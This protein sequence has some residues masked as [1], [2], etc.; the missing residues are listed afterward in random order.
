[1][2]PGGEHA[3]HGA[4]AAYVLG[5]KRW[6]GRPARIPYYNAT[7]YK[8][9][10]RKAVAAWN[11]SGA[12]LRFVA[13]PRRRAR[14]VVSHLGRVPQPQV[15]FGRAQL[16]Y[17]PGRVASVWL[18]RGCASRVVTHVAT[19][20]FGHILGLN[21]ENRRCATMN[22]VGGSGSRCPQVGAQ[23]WMRR[24]RLLEADDVRGAIRRYG[25]RMQPLAPA[26]CEVSPAP[27]APSEL[28]VTFDPA[29]RIV[30]V[31]WRNPTTPGLAF[32][33]VAAK[34]GGCPPSFDDAL[35]LDVQRGALSTASVSVGD[36]SGPYCVGVR[37]ADGY[38]RTN[39]VTTTIEV[40]PP[41]G[42]VPPPP[43]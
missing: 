40:P 28:V 8:A 24:C 23:P 35:G 21:H 39:V 42:E 33:H 36:E 18:P 15:C 17:S 26:F 29:E 6:P 41:P 30:R 11:A 2:V 10:V 16:G 14:V 20:E 13:V 1:M 38:G 34:P 32:A 37:V 25:G 31:S 5:G 7:V 19:H 9:E 3:D 43:E 12:R 22:A 27:G 4:R